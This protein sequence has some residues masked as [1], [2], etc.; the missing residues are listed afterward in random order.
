MPSES[1]VATSPLERLHGVGGALAERFRAIDIDTPA[2]LARVL[3]RDYKDWRKPTRI[4]DI[5][6][7]AIAR[8]GAPEEPES[9]EAIAVG[10]LTNAREVRARVAIVTGDLT[11]GSGRL[12]LTWF[13]RRGLRLNAGDRLFVHGRAQVKFV[14]GAPIVELNVLHHRVLEAGEE[15]EGAVVPVYRG[16]KDLPSRTIAKVIEHNLAD[17]SHYVRPIVPDA[18]VAAHGFDD[19]VTAWRRLHRPV[20]P[21]DAVSAR[22]RMIFEEFFGIAIRATL[23]AR[24]SPCR[25]R[26]ARDR[27][28]TG[29]SCPLSRRRSA[30]RSR[31]RSAARSRRSTPIWANSRR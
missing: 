9:G 24:A 13:G 28:G 23:R 21:E 4:A 15:Y 8:H 10:E 18:I 7:E 30:S 2:K 6:R 26:R 27:R 20:S 22:E 29:V 12:K 11:D 16:S 3:P 19:L 17:L 5:V 1:A 14:R 31:A 25:G